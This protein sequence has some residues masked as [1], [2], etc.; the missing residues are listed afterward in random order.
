MYIRI[1]S[2]RR[3]GDGDISVGYLPKVEKQPQQVISFGK[4]RYVEFV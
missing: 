1:C 3:I 2:M 4:Q